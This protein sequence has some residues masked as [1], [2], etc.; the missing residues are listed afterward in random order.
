MVIDLI[1]KLIDRCIQ[2]VKASQERDRSFFDEFVTP[3]FEQFETVH[4]SYMTTLTAYR[5]ALKEGP[6]F[7]DGYAIALS[8]ARE[9]ILYQSDL[10]SKSFHLAESAGAKH[11]GR[12]ML[13]RE[14]LN[15]F[16]ADIHEY[17]IVNNFNL[18]GPGPH[19]M[20]NNQRWASEVIGSLETLSRDSTLDD[21][22]KRY[23]AIAH[24]D[25][26]V[27][28]MQFMYA[29]VSAAYYTLKAYLV[30]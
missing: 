25:S 23:R 9:Q 14:T 2:L 24:V 29:K 8:L 30:K 12:A 18:Y 15:E 7:E 27:S 26:A 20:Y 28:E 11:D 22:E 16:V 10:R 19:A 5:T 6:S 3:A 4:R 1:D 21:A 13:V 17:L